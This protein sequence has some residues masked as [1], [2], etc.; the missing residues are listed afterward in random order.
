MICENS[1]PAPSCRDPDLRLVG[2]R[3]QVESEESTLAV[4]PEE[5][6]HEL[7]RLNVAGQ[8]MLLAV[9]GG[10]DSM[11]MLHAV[12]RMREQLKL[13]QLESGASQSWTS[14]LRQ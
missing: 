5:L 14:W 8:G 6:Y 12:V 7:E 13:T 2:L 4:F 10:S 3:N 11:A 1:L 9:S